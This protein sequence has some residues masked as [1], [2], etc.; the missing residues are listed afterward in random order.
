MAIFQNPS[1]VKICRGFLFSRPTIQ[2][3]KMRNIILFV[4]L[5]AASAEHVQLGFTKNVLQPFKLKQSVSTLERT[6]KPSFKPTRNPVLEFSPSEA[7]T[8]S[9]TYGSGW[10]IV[11]RNQGSCDVTPDSVL[12][13][14]TETCIKSYADNEDE[15]P[16]YIRA[17]CYTGR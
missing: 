1:P 2:P 11:N 14:R 8:G 15:F 7:P 16:Y 5:A 4:L 3:Q 6:G 9:P 13:V 12:A 17:S 10:L